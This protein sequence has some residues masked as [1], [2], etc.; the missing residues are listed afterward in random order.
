VTG[1]AAIAATRRAEGVDLDRAAESIHG[2]RARV[3]AVGR[4]PDRG[5]VSET[6]LG[7]SR[8][9]RLVFDA[10]VALDVRAVDKR[11]SELFH[12]GTI[13]SG[14]RWEGL[15]V[16]P[17]A[18]M[19]KQGEIG[20]SFALPAGCE[21]LVARLDRLRIAALARALGGGDSPSVRRGIQAVPHT[22]AVLAEMRTRLRFLAGND[23]VLR[24]QALA[25]EQE[26]CERVASLLAASPMQ[27]DR[28]PATR[29]R[30][31]RSALEYARA[32][33]GERI[34]LHDLCA[35]SECS[36]RTLR[37]AFREH[38][39]TSPTAFLKQLRLQGLR[40][41]LQAAMPYANTVVSL[42][43]RWGFWHMGH[44]AHDYKR[45]FGEAPS[46]TLIHRHSDGAVHQNS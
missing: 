13:S 17:D 28:P 45:T 19:L 32:H 38:Y 14:V 30:A 8:V 15:Q 6:V 10:P 46:D 18:L 33:D 20:S 26:L 35:A 9:I 4:G 5:T 43:A 39:G 12:V 1:R 37:T 21:L 25:A 40:R 16:R 42:A 23:L 34:S 3:T 41:N 31:L 7:S 27:L 2:W 36:E 44:L 11:P 29:R 24:E 22:D